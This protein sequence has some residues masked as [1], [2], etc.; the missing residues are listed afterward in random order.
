MYWKYRHLSAIIRVYALIQF[1]LFEILT[2]AKGL[3]LSELIWSTIVVGIKWSVKNSPAV[4]RRYGIARR[5]FYQS[6]CLYGW[7]EC[8]L[9]TNHKR[10]RLLKTLITALSPLPIQVIR[11][12]HLL[13]VSLPQGIIQLAGWRCMQSE[14]WIHQALVLKVQAD[15]KRWGWVR[16]CDIR[17]C[18]RAVDKLWELES[19]I[20]KSCSRSGLLTFVL[21]FAAMRETKK[22][23]LCTS[24]SSHDH[25]ER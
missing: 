23:N 15:D 8:R 2:I 11:S 9:S 3:G 6:S 21:K 17:V 12:D 5:C 16:Q 7:K 22:R 18:E 20:D 10:C 4:L 14:K 1:W 13:F 19:W 24:H 25:I